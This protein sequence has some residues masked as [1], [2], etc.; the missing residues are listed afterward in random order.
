MLGRLMR[1]MH[2]PV[3]RRRLEVLV[4]EILPAL[5]PNDRVLDVGCGNG[6]LGRALLD[7]PGAPPGLVVEGLERV[8][9]G[10]EPIAVHAYDG[11]AI[12]FAA[13]AY[14]VLIVADVLHHERAPEALLRECARVAGRLVIVKDHRV[15]GWFSQARVSFMDWAANAP[16]GV[17]CLYEY[18]SRAG[19]TER[20]RRS[21]LRAERELHRMDLYPPGWNL[22]FGGRLQYMAFLTPE[23]QA[24]AGINAPADVTAARGEAV[25][26]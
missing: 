1:A 12:P 13:R 5:R 20:A 8:R 10:N 4:R 21:G 16:Y 7:A 14:D 26:A 23:S 3:Y 17:P 15:E 18:P 9:R 22:V 25:R 24:P 19:W 11:G 6:T 2:A